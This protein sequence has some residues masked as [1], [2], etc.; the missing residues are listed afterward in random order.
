MSRTVCTSA[1]ALKEDSFMEETA[2]EARGKKGLA[3]G[4]PVEKAFH[5]KQ[6]HPAFG[7]EGG[8]RPGNRSSGGTC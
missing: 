1:R 8:G 6:A 4:Q 5:E 7:W 3:G 2:E